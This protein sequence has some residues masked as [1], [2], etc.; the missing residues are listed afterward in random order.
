MILLIDN[1]DSFSYNLYQLI[2]EQCPDIKVVRNDGITV[3]EI[4]ALSPQAIVLSPGPGKP[5]DAGVCIDA[6]K[7][8][9]GKIPI[10]GVCLG[11]QSICEAYGGKV[12]YAGRIMHGKQSQVYVN[13][14]RL[15]AG[16]GNSFLAGRYHSLEVTDLPKELIV[17]AQTDRKEVMAV[18]HATYPVFG[19]QFHPESILTPCGK[20]ILNNF[21][22]IA[23]I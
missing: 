1:Y 20:Q 11:H 15:F 9:G 12:I 2:G 7:A 10:L 14:G 18:E 23:G 16:L 17:T 21:L 4:D 6:V 13:G 3:K 22:K 19:V 5:K 8:F